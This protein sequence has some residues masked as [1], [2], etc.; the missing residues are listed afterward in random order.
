[1]LWCI[2]ATGKVPR[3][4]SKKPIELAIRHWVPNWYDCSV[5]S[6]VSSQKEVSSAATI[7]IDG[8]L[9][10]CMSSY[11]SKHSYRSKVK[12]I[13]PPGALASALWNHYIDS[14]NERQAIAIYAWCSS[15]NDLWLSFAGAT[16]LLFWFRGGR[17]AAE[18]VGWL[19]KILHVKLDFRSIC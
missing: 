3:I 2:H 6:F 14:F 7:S 1:M 9:D 18:T 19:I 15:I 16:R 4:G 12:E 8:C 5:L 13:S 11:H 10:V 17:F